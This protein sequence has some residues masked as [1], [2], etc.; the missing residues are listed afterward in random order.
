VGGNRRESVERRDYD[1]SVGGSKRDTST[2][3]PREET[4]WH[5]GDGQRN[6]AKLIEREANG[7]HNLRD[8]KDDVFVHWSL[9][10]HDG[11]R[12]IDERHKKR[13]VAVRTEDGG[14]G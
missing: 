3:I 7:V 6:A 11:K 1:W 5:I 12:G 4:D 13:G 2:I 14:G 9:P 8:V 10:P